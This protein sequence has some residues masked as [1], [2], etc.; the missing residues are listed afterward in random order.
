MRPSRHSERC[1]LA[2]QGL[3]LPGFAL[4]RVCSKYSTGLNEGVFPYVFA[5][6]GYIRKKYG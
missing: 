4:A 1:K 5:V 2:R 3:R 6:G